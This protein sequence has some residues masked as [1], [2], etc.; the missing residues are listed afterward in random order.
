MPPEA[1]P[2]DAISPETPLLTIAIPTFNR[3][4]LLAQLLAVLTPNSPPTRKSNSSSAITA[5]PTT[6][7]PS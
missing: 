2:N 3:A 6:P 1:M 4:D 7:P 5:Q